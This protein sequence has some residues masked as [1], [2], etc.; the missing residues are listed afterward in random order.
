M[1]KYFVYKYTFPDGKIYI[2]RSGTYANRYGNPGKYK[3]Q[4]VYNHMIQYP[5]F[6][7]EKIFETDDLEECIIREHDEINKTWTINLNKSKE[8]RYLE[9][10]EKLKEQ[11]IIPTKEAVTQEYTAEEY[12]RN[13]K[14][15]HCWFYYNWWKVIIPL[16]I[17]YFITGGFIA[18]VNYA[19]NTSYE[20][21]N[22]KSHIIESSYKEPNISHTIITTAANPAKPNAD[23]YNYVLEFQYI[24]RNIAYCGNES[25]QLLEYFIYN[26]KNNKFMYFKNLH[27]YEKEIT[28]IHDTLCMNGITSTRGELTYFTITEIEIYKY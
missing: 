17:L 9:K 16:I 4:K 27:D 19:N 12:Y 20:T 26:K 18:L 28:N 23:D 11:G 15:D 24:T 10:I 25:N 8:K 5:N 6:K 1:N 13:N 22:N 3:K 21:Y 2:G 14:E 7:K